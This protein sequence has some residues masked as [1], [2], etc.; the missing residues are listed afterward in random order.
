[1]DSLELSKQYE[2]LSVSRLYL[3]SL[4]FSNE[5]IQSLSDADMERIAEK[6]NTMY[7]TDFEGDVRFLVACEIIEKLSTGGITDNRIK[8]ETYGTN[9]NE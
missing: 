9:T 6:L 1:L 8:G 2:V 4:G 5:G 3:R 7:S